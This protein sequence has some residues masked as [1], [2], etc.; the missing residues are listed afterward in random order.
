MDESL[1]LGVIA[2]HHPEPQDTQTP[3]TTKPQQKPQI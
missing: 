3:Q 2:E 1:A